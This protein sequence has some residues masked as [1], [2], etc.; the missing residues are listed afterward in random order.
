VLADRV[1]QR[2]QVLEQLVGVHVDLP[3]DEALLAQDLEHLL[4]LAGQGQPGHPADRL[5]EPSGRWSTAPKSMTPSRP[6]GSSRKLPGCGSACSRPASTGPENRKRA[7]SSDARSR[8]S[9]VPVA[10]ICESGTPS[11]HSVT[12]IRSVPATTRGTVI[13][14]SPSY[15][16]TKVVCDSASRR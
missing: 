1:E 15:A 12:R 10:M 11:I 13:S 7:S 2:Q 8:C 16:S 6:S 14:S 9:W 4:G 5:G 3:A